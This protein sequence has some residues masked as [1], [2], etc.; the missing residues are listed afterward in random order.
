MDKNEIE[1]YLKRLKEIDNQ[2]N[3]D[4]VDENVFNEIERIISDLDNEI[5]HDESSLAV[6]VKKLHHDS[7]IPNY[8][9]QGDAGLD[10]TAT[11]IINET[12]LQVSYGT[13]LSFE[14]PDGY[15]GLLYPRSSI[16]KYNLLLSN[17][18]GVIDSGYRGE[19]MLT[20]IKTN[21][22]FSEKYNVGDRIGQ[23]IILPYP[24]VKLIESN[25]L[26][27]SERGHGGFGHT[28]D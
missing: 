4:N 5:K 17:S 22:N 1:S 16:R 7:I 11:R 2:L 14:I 24:K 25:T 10:L 27:D 23:I 26:S 13:D 3:D 12:E 21:G 28:G 18:V 15:V 19:I 6:K 9:K 20:F 8:A